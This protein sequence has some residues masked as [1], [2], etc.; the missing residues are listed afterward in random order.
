MY[1][2][3]LSAV[4]ANIYLHNYDFLVA[5]NLASKTK[6]YFTISLILC[7]F[8]FTVALSFTHLS[9]SVYLPISI[10]ALSVSVCMCI[11]YGCGFFL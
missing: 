10:V 7:F 8:G 4:F 2:A 9:V 11:T 3:C 6:I 1:C 5:I